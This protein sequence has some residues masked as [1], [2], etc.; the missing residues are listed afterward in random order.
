MEAAAQPARAVGDGGGM[1]R[2]PRG[3]GGSAMTV[4]R[5][6]EGRSSPDRVSGSR[7]LDG[8]ARLLRT[9]RAAVLYTRSSG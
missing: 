1:R 4:F 9:A 2:P 8:G 7:A 6:R 3:R 5:L